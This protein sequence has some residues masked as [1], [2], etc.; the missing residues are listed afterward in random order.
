MLRAVI[1]SKAKDYYYRRDAKRF[2]YPKDDEVREHL[3]L[4]AFIFETVWLPAHS[5][6]F[7]LASRGAASY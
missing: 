1:D 4:A 5:R 6:L 3:R 7:E 2:L